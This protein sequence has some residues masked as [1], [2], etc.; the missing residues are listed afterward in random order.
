MLNTA[1]QLALRAGASS[2]GS[3]VIDAKER[4]DHAKSFKDTAEQRANVSNYTKLGDQV[5][6]QAALVTVAVGAMALAYSSISEQLREVGNQR[7][8]YFK[9]RAAGT[10]SFVLPTNKEPREMYTEENFIK[11]FMQLT[12][13]NK[14]SFAT[15]SCQQSTML[16]EQS[17]LFYSVLPFYRTSEHLGQPFKN[18]RLLDRQRR[19]IDLFLKSAVPDFLYDLDKSFRHEWRVTSFFSST[20]NGAN[21]TNDFRSARFII[22]SLANLLWSLQHPVDPETSYPHTLDNCIKLCRDV[23][24][25]LN[26]ILAILTGPC[27]KQMKK[28]N[29]LASFVRKV[30]T[31]INALWDAY[32][33]ER[34]HE[35]NIDEVTSSAH[36]ALEIMDKSILNILYKQHTLKTCDSTFNSADSLV[37]KISYL[38]G[39]FLINPEL[40]SMFPASNNLNAGAMLLNNPAITVIDALIIFCHMSK[41]DRVN[42]I[43]TLKKSSFS[44]VLELATTLTKLHTDVIK[45]VDKIS[46][47]E[48]SKLNGDQSYRARAVLTARRLIPFMTFVIDDYGIDIDT[49][50]ILQKIK[51]MNTPSQR[52]GKQQIKFINEMV[53][54]NDPLAYYQLTL[55]PFL[56]ASAETVDAL[57]ELVFHQTRMRHVT[58]LL[59]GISELIHDYRNFLQHQEFQTFL[60]KCLSRVKNEYGAM[61]ERIDK[62]DKKITDDESMSQELRQI[63]GQMT[64]EMD[65][66]LTAFT[67]ATTNLNRVIGSPSFPE[68]QKKLLTK[69]I[70][71]IN[72]QYLILFGE[73]SGLDAWST[74]GEQH[75]GLELFGSSSNI[76]TN[77]T[78]LPE[79]KVQ[80]HKVIAL[81]KL[82]HACYDGLSYIS[83][84]GY[85]GLL[86]RNLM[87]Q[88][89]TNPDFTQRQFNQAIKELVRVSASYRETYFFQATYGQS[90]SAKIIIKAIK[91]PHLTTILPLGSILFGTEGV[92]YTE[93]SD[94]QIVKALDALRNQHHWQASAGRMIGKTSFDLPDELPDSPALRLSLDTQSSPI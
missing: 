59:D 82:A 93:Q 65:N 84:Y 61:N 80:S 34:L 5:S 86:L 58:K 45:P 52:N 69:K 43:E 13:E 55:S 77:L 75:S 27:F 26:N 33:D 3:N 85:K 81:S 31:H 17:N 35:V 4:E 12:T 56:N 83:R 73:G 44:S 37:D 68:E 63:L 7:L 49:P 79:V 18:H 36:Q 72:Q 62:L 53:Q 66:R 6:A 42:L 28:S 21:Y 39:L 71:A 22:M 29:V 9:E 57:N 60:K 46:K 94:D 48:L 24:N 51:N 1:A 10:A 89:D 2:L 50:F 23:R 38:Q 8:A 78:P 90:R 87:N 91:D 25:Y 32:E 47:E 67:K 64:S 88:I 74:T 76:S 16:P 19:T 41:P 54:L 30:D 20:W 11:K 70:D 14:P 40:I 92:N 15:Y